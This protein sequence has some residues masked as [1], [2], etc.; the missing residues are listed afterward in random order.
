MAFNKK[1]ELRLYVPVHS[2]VAGDMPD[3]WYRGLSNNAQLIKDRLLEKIPDEAAF[4]RIIV[5]PSTNGFAN[6][7]NPAFKSKRGANANIIRATKFENLSTMFAEWYRRIGKVY[8]NNAALFNSAIADAKDWVAERLGAKVLRFT[9]DKIRGRGPAPLATLYMAGDLRATIWGGQGDTKEGAPYDIS[10]DNEGSTFKAALQQRLVQ[11]GMRIVNTKFD[12]DVITAENTTNASVLNGQRDTAK[13][14][15][16]VLTTGVEDC[17]CL[18]EVDIEGRL[19]LH[20]QV[21]VTVP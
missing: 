16:F 4:M 10:R 2:E 12:T 14:D 21:G 20:V 11:S 3:K 1:F 5:D 7:I 18:W 15:E 9:G 17:F 8:A 19:N 6:F 13:C